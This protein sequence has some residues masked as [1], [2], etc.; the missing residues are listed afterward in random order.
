MKWITRKDFKVDRVA[1]HLS[2]M[3]FRVNRPSLASTLNYEKIRKTPMIAPPVRVT[4]PTVA[5]MPLYPAK[6]RRM[7]RI[8]ATIGWWSGEPSRAKVSPTYAVAALLSSCV[9]VDI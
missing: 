7:R 1:C 6:L 2:L 5:P 9:G 8:Q 4:L 3:A